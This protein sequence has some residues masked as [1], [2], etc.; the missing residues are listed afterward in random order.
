MQNEARVQ[1]DNCGKLLLPNKIRK[2]YNIKTGDVFI[3][4]IIDEEIKLVPLDKVLK[5]AKILIRKY[6]FKGDS[7]NQE[8]IDSRQ[9]EF[10]ET[11]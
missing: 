5:D 9:Q 11:K 4:K 6:I 2:Q 1:I 8:L 3:I 7:L 10:R